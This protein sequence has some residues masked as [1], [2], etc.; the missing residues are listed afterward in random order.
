MT[1][2][3]MAQL[4]FF[5]PN[6]WT[7]ADDERGTIVYRPEVFDHE[8]A[9]TLF[10]RLRTE[11]PWSED[12]MRMYD[13]TV[14]VPRLRYNYSDAAAAPKPL[15]RIHERV[16]Q[17]EATT[18]NRIGLN[19][20]RDGNDSVA[21]HS[22]HE[23]DMIERP[24]VVVVSLGVPRP[25]DIRERIDHRRHWRLTLEPGSLLVMRGYAQRHYEHRIA[26]LS[27]PTQ[28]RV[29][30]ALRQYAGEGQAPQH[31]AQCAGG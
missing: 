26:K 30:I 20:Y 11:V 29:S 9:E 8:E 1:V 28:P 31:C 15:Q 3:L 7:L 13:R 27:A 25:M 18:F 2:I 21:W 10:D 5:E 4:G 17:L 22:D 6:D 16:S 12:S 23:E 14:A 19:F 24:T